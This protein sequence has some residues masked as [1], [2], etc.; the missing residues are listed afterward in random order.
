MGCTALLAAGLG[1][2]FA[3]FPV[4]EPRGV[5]LWLAVGAACLQRCAVG[6][7]APGL[8]LASAAGL[9]AAIGG[10]LEQTAVLSIALAAALTAAGPER[11]FAALAVAMGSLAAS[12]LCPG[13][14]AAAPGCLRWAVRWGRWPRP[15][16]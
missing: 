12:C 9:C 4:R 7:L 8:V 3:S 6:P 14:A 15:M 10:T 1:W 16:Q 2:A 13:S 11:A 5:C